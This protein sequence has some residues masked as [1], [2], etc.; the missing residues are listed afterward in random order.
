[1]DLKTALLDWA[2]KASVENPPTERDRPL[3]RP[4]EIVR[5]HVFCVR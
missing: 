1:M 3:R 5:Q 4:E 2:T